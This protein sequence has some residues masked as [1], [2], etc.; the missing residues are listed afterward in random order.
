MQ[1][2]EGFDRK[3]ISRANRVK[4]N[5]K[6]FKKLQDK[7]FLGIF[8]DISIFYVDYCFKIW[9]SR[10]EI[11]LFSIVFHSLNAEFKLLKLKTSKQALFKA[12]FYMLFNSNFPFISFNSLQSPQLPLMKY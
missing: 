9:V 8:L 2:C 1:I 3:R 4:E 11:S 6:A 7:K 10:I 12:F 5:L